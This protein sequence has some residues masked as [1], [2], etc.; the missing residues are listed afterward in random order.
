MNGNMQ[1]TDIERRTEDEKRVIV[2]VAK[3]LRPGWFGEV[4]IT[5][6]NGRMAHVKTMQTQKA[7]EIKVE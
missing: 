1:P 5:I 3:N 4:L 7:E 2:A 6:Q